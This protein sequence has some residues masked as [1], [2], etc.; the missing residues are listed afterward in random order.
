[1]EPRFLNSSQ[2]DLVARFVGQYKDAPLKTSSMIDVCAWGPD[3]EAIQLAEQILQALGQSGCKVTRE[4]PGKYG[5][6][7]NE[8]WMGYDPRNPQ[9]QNIAAGVV[10][11][12]RNAGLFVQPVEPMHIDP[13]TGHLD[14][15]IRIIVGKH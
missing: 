8:I 12:L 1:M 14:S 6:V 15:P 4:Q 13:S 10:G 3:P 2:A 7:P 11:A 5:Q 9:W